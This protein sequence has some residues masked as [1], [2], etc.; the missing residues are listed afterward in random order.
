MRRL[1]RIALKIAAF[2][3]ALCMILAIAAVLVLRSD[4]VHEKVR[5]GIVAEVEK[6]TGGVATLE[7]YRFYW[8][9]LR[10][11]VRGFTLRG[12]EP[13][14]APPL[15]ETPSIQVGLKIVSL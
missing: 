8:R 12:T 1:P 13:A 15:F 10:A 2:L 11:E 3:A 4:W 6:A 7:G 14:G 5:Q 9:G